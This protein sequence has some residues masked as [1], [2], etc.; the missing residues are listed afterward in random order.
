MT[1]GDLKGILGLPD[2]HDVVKGQ[3]VHDADRFM[4]TIVPL[5][6][7]GKMQIHFCRGE[8]TNLGHE[9]ITSILKQSPTRKNQGP[10]VLGELSAGH[11]LLRPLPGEKVLNH[12]G[13]FLLHHPS[14]NLEGV[15]ETCIRMN[16]IQGA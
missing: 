11:S 3:G 14:G 13:A 5:W 6:A 10:R 9:W 7:N 1:W 2:R 4:I 16:A 12:L 8:H 15:V